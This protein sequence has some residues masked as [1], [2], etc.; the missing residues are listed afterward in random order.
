MKRAAALAAAITLLLL[1]APA[2]SLG[3]FRPKPVE[4]GLAPSPASVERD[5][6]GKL[7][8]APLRAPKRFNL[9]GLTWAG[10]GE[11]EID[12]RVRETGEDWG[13]WTDAPAHPDGGPDPG[14]P[15]RS[16][17]GVSSPVWAGEADFV[18]YRLSK[19]L[20]NLRLKFVNASGT[21][22]A[23]G[24][25][26][27]G[28]IGTLTGAS[29]AF[30]GLLTARADS[31]PTINPRSSWG[32][33]DCPPRRAASYGSVKA[34]FVH[35]TSPETNDYSRSQVPAL[36][37][38]HC[39]Y[40][41]NS[42]GWD[43]IGYN[44]VV[45]KYGK[46]WEGRAGGVD[47]AVVGA[48]ARG[49]N[50]E[51]VGIASLGTNS[52][53]KATSASL[54]AMA[55]LIRWKLPLHGQPT[56]GSVRLKSAGGEGNRHPA[57]RLVNF[58]RVSGHRNAVHTTCPGDALYAQLPDLRRLVEKIAY[59]GGGATYT[60]N[61]DGT[62]RRRVSSSGADGDPALSPLGTK[63]AF[64]RTRGADRDIWSM[65]ADGSG[66]RQLTSNPTLDAHPSWSPGGTKL[67]FIR[68]LSGNL[69]I[70]TMNP[71]G[72]GAARLT[73]AS[74]RDYA[75][76]WSRSGR[77]AFVREAGGNDD[78]Y[79]MSPDGSGLRRVTSRSAKDTSPSWSPGSTKIA[80]VRSGNIYTVNPDGSALRR[81]TT[82]GGLDP[83]WA[84]NGA[85]IAFSRGASGEREVYLMNADGSGL[86]RVTTES[87]DARD[88]DW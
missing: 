45:D 7:L 42:N 70:H 38:S 34:S 22:T 13:P 32:A 3:P 25:V 55:R 50:S 77:I 69:D 66:Q 60:V 23:G 44:F 10:E 41:R 4:F 18:Q 59:A 74:G 65:N 64:E 82:S 88:P 67:L 14:T 24:R 1:A 63:I 83:S 36:I 35:H 46:I 54:T 49:F 85:K 2:L 62:Q 33:S 15:E 72:S 31:Q 57:G 6:Q 76:A 52:S 58:D 21:A 30:T 84:S 28:V 56:E 17:E 8:S 43:D 5:A 71:D 73:K 19:S 12:L 86:Q 47:K 11:A 53:V 29:Q 51:S 16:A 9:V 79:T 26:K 81:L 27:A 20:P 78:I 40:H 48:H 68:D 61:P 87:A 75:P 37:L 39:L 80:F